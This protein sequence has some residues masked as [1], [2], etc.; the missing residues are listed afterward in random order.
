MSMQPAEFKRKWSSALLTERA[1]AQQHFLDL[2]S[3]VGMPP[4]AV[5][6][7]TG[8]RFAFERA[9]SKAGGGKGFAD[10]WFR[11][12]FAMEY[13]GPGA[14]LD[15]AYQQL[16]LYRD[17]LDNPPL[18]VVSDLRRI[19]IHTNF[20]RAPKRVHEID[21]DSIDQPDSQRTLRALFFDPDLLHPRITVSQVTELANDGG[22]VGVTTAKN[23][24]V[25]IKRIN[26]T[27]F[28][29]Y[30][31][32]CPHQGVTVMPESGEREW[33]CPGHGAKFDSRTG[34]KISGPARR[35]LTKIKTA[36]NGDI[37]TV[38]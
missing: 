25:G 7:P 31:L 21:L 22:A 35:G 14:D 12:H 23:K 18:L 15:R 8:E 33:E 2:C 3:L 11:D 13:K 6:D 16:L 27:T 19:L 4:P 38:G 30:D 20:T 10:V 5:Y 26:A 37:L 17:D 29:A 32:K 36:L 24:P 34:A 1:S 28:A 9:V